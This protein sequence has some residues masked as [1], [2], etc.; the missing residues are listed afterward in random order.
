[1]GDGAKRT[2]TVSG[3]TSNYGGAQKRKASSRELAFEIVQNE[4]GG[5]AKQIVYGRHSWPRQSSIARRHRSDV[6]HRLQVSQRFELFDRKPPNEQLCGLLFEKDLKAELLE[7]RDALLRL[8]QPAGVQPLA[9]GV[10]EPHLNRG[11]AV[12][13]EGFFLWARLCHLLH[14]SLDDGCKRRVQLRKNLAAFQVFG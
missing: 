3:I 11:F 8:R 1:M 2:L 9:G 12:D 13:N 4:R 7:R 6:A 14:Q 10:V 5:G